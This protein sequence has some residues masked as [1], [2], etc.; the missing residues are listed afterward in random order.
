[1]IK[2]C[3]TI[4]FDIKDISKTIRKELINENHI[5][6]LNHLLELPG[7][8]VNTVEDTVYIYN[9]DHISE[10]AL[11]AMVERFL[12]QGRSTIKF[13][14]ETLKINYDY[15]AAEKKSEPITDK[16]PSATP[17][18]ANKQIRLDL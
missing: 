6:F 2:V 17:N 13:Y 16:V 11:G 12:I 15:N 9:A 5:K 3:R 14:T 10:F 18:Q 4:I 8:A 7:I 1:M